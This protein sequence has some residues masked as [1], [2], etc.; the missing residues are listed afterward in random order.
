MECWVQMDSKALDHRTKVGMDEDH[1]APQYLGDV[2][3]HEV[4][5]SARK[6]GEA[7]GHPDLICLCSACEVGCFRRAPVLCGPWAF[8]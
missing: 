1:I 7:I 3:R 2:F 5:E 8:G 6:R 4:A